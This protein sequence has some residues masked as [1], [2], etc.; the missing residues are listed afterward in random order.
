[1]SNGV[2]VAIVG[3]LHPLL[4]MAQHLLEGSVLMLEV[5]V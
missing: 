2:D 1:M 5:R 3:G 4:H